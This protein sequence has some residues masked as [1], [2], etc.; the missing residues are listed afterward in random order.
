M[1]NR[2]PVK[3]RLAA[4]LGEERARDLYRQVTEQVW[5]QLQHP[6]LERWLWMVNEDALVAGS[7]WLTGADRVLSQCNGNLGARM[8]HAFEVVHRTGAASCSIVGTDA[9]AVD[10]K[11]VLTADSLLNHSALALAPAHDGG[12]ALIAARQAHPEL[13]REIPWSTEHVLTLTLERAASVQLTV[14][15]LPVVRDLDT[16]ADLKALTASGEL[17]PQCDS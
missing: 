5:A 9:P 12:Y 1:W 10:A 16:A 2:G 7:N 13:F 3:T 17:S 6:E 4:D 14:E 15:Q 8:L 11:M